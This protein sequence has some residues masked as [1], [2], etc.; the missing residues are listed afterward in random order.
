MESLRLKL[1]QP[2]VPLQEDN[3]K[4]DV[5]RGMLAKRSASAPSPKEELKAPIGLR[6]HLGHVQMSIFLEVFRSPARLQHLRTS[7]FSRSKRRSSRIFAWIID[8]FHQI[9]IDFHVVRS[10]TWLLVRRPKLQP[11]HG[12]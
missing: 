12:S 10:F 2:L 6:S 8:R 3:V 1:F 7:L 4:A 5:Q 9:S 11:A